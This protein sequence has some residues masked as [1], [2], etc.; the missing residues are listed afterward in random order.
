MNDVSAIV[1]LPR[2]F[3]SCLGSKH[4]VSCTSYSGY[5]PI[6]ANVT[7]KSLI[8]KA[9]TVVTKVTAKKGCLTRCEGEGEGE[10]IF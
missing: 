7:V 3:L 1:E 4:V 6:F 10:K 5:R 9:V 2:N 8:L